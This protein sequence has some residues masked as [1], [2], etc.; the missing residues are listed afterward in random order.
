MIYS[1]IC[2]DPFRVSL[3]RIVRWGP[4]RF[5]ISFVLF[6]EAISHILEFALESATPKE[7]NKTILTEPALD[8]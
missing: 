7:R 2:W 1:N 4:C 3:P 5:S 8:Q 6:W